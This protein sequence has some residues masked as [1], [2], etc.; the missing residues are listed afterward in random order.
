MIVI[1]AIIYQTTQVILLN[2]KFE[3]DSLTQNVTVGSFDIYFHGLFI[4]FNW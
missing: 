1:T 2:E 3:Q 4:F